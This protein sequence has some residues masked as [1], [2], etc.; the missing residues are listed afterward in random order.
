MLPISSTPSHS[1]THPQI[2]IVED[3]PFGFDHVF[4]QTATQ[5]EV[6]E[7]IGRPLVEKMLSGFNCSLLAYGQSGN[8]KTFTMGLD[9]A[10]ELGKS[11]TKAGIIIRT[12]RSIFEA[13]SDNTEISDLNLEVSFI[14]IYNERVYDLLSPT[15]T[16]AENI[17]GPFKKLFTKRAMKTEADAQEILTEAYQKRHVRPTKINLASSRSHA[18]FTI[19]ATIKNSDYC[20]IHSEL[21]LVD[22]AGAEGVRKTGHH[23]Q[24]L[25]EGVNINQGLLS[26]GRILQAIAK[27]DKVIPYRESVL[28]RVLQESLNRNCFLTLLACVSPSKFDS[29]ETLSTLRFAENVGTLKNNPKINV[30][31]NEITMARRKTPTKQ[32]FTPRPTSTIKRNRSTINNTTTTLKKKCLNFP[33]KANTTLTAKKEQQQQQMGMRRPSYYPNAEPPQSMTSRRTT[34]ETD[35]SFAGNISTSTFISNHQPQLIDTSQMNFSPVIR[36]CMST[37]E[38]KLDERISAAV[39]DIASRFMN[40]SVVKRQ[41]SIDLGEDQPKRRRS[42]RASCIAI[43]PV[44]DADVV[45]KVPHQPAAKSQEGEA[46]EEL[47]NTFDLGNDSTLFDVS[48]STM[49]QGE[50]SKTTLRRSRRVQELNESKLMEQEKMVGQLPPAKERKSQKQTKPKFVRDKYLS[51]Y[52]RLSTQMECPKEEDEEELEMKVVE[53][54]KGRKDKKAL[55]KGPQNTHATGV[56]SILNNG[57]LKELQILPQIGL[58]T[59]YQIMTYR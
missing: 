44:L 10:N 31:M 43:A 19:Y 38:S 47:N 35:F 8:G 27:G 6:F 24:A 26:V 21:N 34:T 14:E 42:S 1:P 59:A 46:L 13:V 40:N 9:G 54:R 53:S 25:A 28:T 32:M 30:I 22:L 45:F 56:L 50:T 57:N 7:S 55:G 15:F 5:E 48:N 58:K 51:S 16:E 3:R 18:V 20:S 41:S 4:G 12:L 49:I 36:K 37:F 11:E 29:K 2:I 23:G 17:R 33:E 52:F 39:N